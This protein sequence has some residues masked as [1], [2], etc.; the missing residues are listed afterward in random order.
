MPAQ[1]VL[2]GPLLLKHILARFLLFASRLAAASARPGV[3]AASY[4]LPA[5]T[6]DIRAGLTRVQPHWVVHT[7]SAKGR[8]IGRALAD[9]LATEFRERSPRYYVCPFS[10]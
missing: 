7:T 4:P 8:W 6:V 1:P 5:R 3:S 9:V 10:F 2:D